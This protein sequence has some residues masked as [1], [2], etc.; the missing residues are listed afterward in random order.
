MEKENIGFDNFIEHFDCEIYAY[1]CDEV[2]GG[3][4]QLQ[5]IVWDD[6]TQQKF[7]KSTKSNIKIIGILR[8]RDYTSDRAFK[9]DKKFI[10][11]R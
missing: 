7:Y 11:D 1:I 9:K 10:A 8:E 2:V 5:F 3:R 4:L 6:V